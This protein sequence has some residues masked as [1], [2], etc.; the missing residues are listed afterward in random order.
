MYKNIVFDFGNVLAH[1][2]E[3][4]ITSCYLTDQKEIETVRDVVFNRPKP[5]DMLDG[6]EMSVSEAKEYFRKSFSSD[7][8]Y[9]TACKILDNWMFNLPLF[10]GA[11]EMISEL[12]SKGAKIY[13]ISNINM[14]FADRCM[15][16]PSLNRLFSMFDGLVFSAKEAMRKPDPEIFRRL[17]ERYSLVPGECIFVDDTAENHTG[18]KQAGMNTYLFDGD[19]QKLKAELLKRG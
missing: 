1:F 16:V 14:T 13:L 12:K 10:F 5:W 19:I 15:E 4:E 18:A 2:D 6:D 9:E 17:T 7:R 11:T 3:T 8:L